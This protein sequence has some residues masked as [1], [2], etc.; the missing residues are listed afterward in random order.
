MEFEVNKLF[1]TAKRTG[2]DFIFSDVHDYWI[3][4]F[5]MVIGKATVWCLLQRPRYGGA[6]LIQ[7]STEIEVLRPYA[8]EMCQ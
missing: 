6:R 5:R 4:L 3:E 1:E 2:A 7:S 8:M